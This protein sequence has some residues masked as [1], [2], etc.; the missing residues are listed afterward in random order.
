[1]Q[2]AMTLPPGCVTGVGS[3]PH[4]D[5]Q[6]AVD[7]VAAHTPELPFWP[8]L[9]K[10]SQREWMVTQALGWCRDLI[11]TQ[12]PFGFRIATGRRSA[13]ADRLDQAPSLLQDHAAG[14]FAF[15][16]ALRDG[17]LPQAVAV[18]GQLEGPITLASYLFDEDVPL[19]ATP[20]YFKVASYI[21]RLAAWQIHR[22]EQSGLPVLLVLDEPVLGLL[23]RLGSVQNSQ[24]E[25]AMTGLRQVTRSVRQHG[26][27]V[28]VHCCTP[29][30]SGLV[31]H[32]DLDYLSWDAHQSLVEGQD[33]ALQAWFRAGGYVGLGLVPTQRPPEGYSVDKLHRRWL[34]VASFLGNLPQVAQQSVVTATCGLGL[35][36][37]GTAFASFQAARALQAELRSIASGAAQ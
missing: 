29:L 22:L 24:A 18:K 7:F 27:W 36:D 31:Q 14:F 30:P 28:G 8:Q 26:A 21:A 6:S 37:S 11:E 33:P 1:M 32:L 34:S 10:R 23:N 16:R 12:P 20:F 13:F 2:P 3:L 19:L 35:Q 17:Q 5:A 15:E 25:V 9:P 4:T